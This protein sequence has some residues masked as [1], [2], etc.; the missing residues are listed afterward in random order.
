M[1][2]H[3]S[4]QAEERIGRDDLLIAR[5]R[6]ATTARMPNRGFVPQEPASTDSLKSRRR[7][8]RPSED[9]PSSSM[10][11]WANDE[12]GADSADCTDAIPSRRTRRRIGG[13]HDARA[14]GG[15]PRQR[16][17]D[18]DPRFWEL[19]GA[20]PPCTRRPQ[21]QD[22]NAG[23]TPGETCSL[24]Q[25]RKAFA[26]TPESRAGIMNRRWTGR[27]VPNRRPGTRS[28]SASAVRC[29]RAHRSPALVAAG[30]PSHAQSL[31]MNAPP[32][33]TPTR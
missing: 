12:V 2:E 32:T 27:S 9:M 25:A 28:R 3:P 1:A 8:H 13:E 29:S 16:R 26:R 18:R 23:V 21:S 15:V 31:S 17:P 7:H 20:L 24:L 14:H 11:Q 30:K 22:R 10:G 6:S 19:L 5:W 33:S 4:P